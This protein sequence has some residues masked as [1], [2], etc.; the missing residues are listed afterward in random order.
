MSKGR[1]M[2]A[3]DLTESVAIRS[4]ALATDSQGGQAETPSTLDTVPAQIA[5]LST[6]ARLA[7]RAVGADTSYLVKIRQRGDVTDKM[8]L[9]WTPRYDFSATQKTLE[10]SGMYTDPANTWLMVLECEERT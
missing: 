1:R 2:T 5:A 7:A 3:G 4:I 10:I 6:R 8:R 9:L